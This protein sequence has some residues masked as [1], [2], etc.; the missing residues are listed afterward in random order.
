MLV[1]ELGGAAVQG[2]D[3]RVYDFAQ[4]EV[5]LGGVEVADEVVED[6]SGYFHDG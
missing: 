6:Y 5:G 2:V 4:F 1:V 3:A